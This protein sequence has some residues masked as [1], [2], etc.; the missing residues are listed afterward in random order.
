MSGFDH[1]LGWVHEA[2]E[3][4]QALREA[5]EEEQERERFKRERPKMS[6]VREARRP[7]SFQERQALI[8]EQGEAKNKTK[9]DLAGTHYER[10]VKLDDDSFDILMPL[11]GL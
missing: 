5:F 9:L 7:H 6:A 4:P 10:K 1:V 8:D 3:D 11:F 2:A